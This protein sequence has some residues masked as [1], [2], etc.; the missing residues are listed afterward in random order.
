MDLREESGVYRGGYS[1]ERKREGE[2]KGERVVSFS[3]TWGRVYRR[4]ESSMD[5]R[6]RV[7]GYREEV[8][9][10]DTNMAVGRYGLESE[11]NIHS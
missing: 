6:G 5:L 10:G 3:A 2:G 8:F 9:G 7:G 4:G 11:R 1:G